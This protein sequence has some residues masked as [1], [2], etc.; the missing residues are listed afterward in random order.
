MLMLGVCG[1]IGVAGVEGVMATA[2]VSSHRLFLLLA[3]GVGV[4]WIM[5]TSVRCTFGVSAHPL[6]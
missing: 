5:S 1:V 3:E 6:L 2:G 4:S